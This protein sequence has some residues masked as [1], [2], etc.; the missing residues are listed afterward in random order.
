MRLALDDLNSHRKSQEILPSKIQSTQQM[1]DRIKSAPNFRG[2][3]Q[4]VNISFLFL[5]IY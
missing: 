5:L 1:Y 2:I 4:K 3:Y